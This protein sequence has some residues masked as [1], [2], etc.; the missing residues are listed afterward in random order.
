MAAQ[1]SAIT[2]TVLHEMI[3]W[4]NVLRDM[5]IMQNLESET[6]LVHAIA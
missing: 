4:Y 3:D 2:N 1:R 5:P 6:A